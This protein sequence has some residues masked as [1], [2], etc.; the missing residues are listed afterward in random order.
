M[1]I[2][3]YIFYNFQA[4]VGSLILVRLPDENDLFVF[5]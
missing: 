5:W 4:A 1:K 2:Q 3:K